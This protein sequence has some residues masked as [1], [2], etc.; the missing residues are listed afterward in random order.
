[1][2]GSPSKNP[3]H[4]L[5]NH[6]KTQVHAFVHNSSNRKPEPLA[7]TVSGRCDTCSKHR[8]GLTELNNAFVLITPGF[9]AALLDGFSAFGDVGS[10][11][12]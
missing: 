7:T 8:G 11:G 6:R 2:A 1:M 5:I 10:V 12:R 4:R 9:G 3:F